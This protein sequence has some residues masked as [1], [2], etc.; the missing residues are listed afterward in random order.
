MA[1]PKQQLIARTGWILLV[2]LP[3]VAIL[4]ADIV[5]GPYIQT[6]ILLIIPVGLAAWGFGRVAGV[7]VAAA[8]VG[9][10]FGIAISFEQVINPLWA[11][12]VNAGIRL[13]VLAGLAILVADARERRALL[14]RVQVLE[15]IL[16]ICMFCKKIRRADGSWEPIEQYVGRHSTASFTHTFCRPCGQEHYG[17]LTATSSTTSRRDTSG[18]S[19]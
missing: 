2:L 12:F 1:T 11:A 6:S 3:A 14:A 13:S 17:D 4:A 15:G 7:V 9:C 16:P 10:R 19:A 5:T 18:P 8:L